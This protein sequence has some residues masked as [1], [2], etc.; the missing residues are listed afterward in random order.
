MHAPLFARVY[1]RYWRPLF[2]SVAGGQRSNFEV[3]LAWLFDQ[4]RAAEGGLVLDHSCG[5]GLVARRLAKSGRFSRVFALDHAR[6]MVA[7]CRDECAVE[8]VD[9]LE[10]IRAEALSLPFADASLDAVH[11]GAALHI[12]PDV[13]AALAEIA[14]VLRPGG[15]FVAS[16]FE[17]ATESRGWGRRALGPGGAKVFGRGE[18]KGLCSRAGFQAYADRRVGS[19]VWFRCERGP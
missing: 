13:D 18:L 7:R 11:A 4:L 6:A 14:R 19:M 3:E 1:E 12:W 9:N 16:T 15:L 2:V 5:P 8:S 10:L 17:E